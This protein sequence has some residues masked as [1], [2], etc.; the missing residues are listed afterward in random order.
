MLYNNTRE[1]N[2]NGSQ[3]ILDRWRSEH[4][5]TYC[6]SQH[7]FTH[8]SCNIIYNQSTAKLLLG[9]VK[10]NY[11]KSKLYIYIFYDYLNTTIE[12]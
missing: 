9:S 10:Y 8:V 6:G 2:S 11:K 7:S 3:N 1:L 12:I 4:W 5:S